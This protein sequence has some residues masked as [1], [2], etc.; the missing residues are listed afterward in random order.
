[1]RSKRATKVF[2]TIEF[3]AI[4]LKEPYIFVAGFKGTALV[5][6]RSRQVGGDEVRYTDEWRPPTAIIESTV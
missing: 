1:M 4:L 5:L 6:D 3:P 2:L